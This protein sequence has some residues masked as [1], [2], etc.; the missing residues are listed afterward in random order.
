MSQLSDLVEDYLADCRAR[1]LSRKTVVRIYGGV[2]S[3]DFLPWCAKASLE[4]I[5]QVDQR[6]LNRWSATLSDRNLTPATISSYTRALN[7]FLRWAREEGG[8]GVTAHLPKQP[9]KIVETLTEEEIDQLAAAAK[10]KRDELIVRTLAGTG[11]RAAELLGMTLDDLRDEGGRYFIRVRMGKGGKSRDVPI[12]PLLFRDLRRYARGT[13]TEG[14]IWLGSN[15][16]R[17]TG[18]YEPLTYDGLHQVIQALTDRAGIRR[19][20]Y[21]HIFRHT[22]I[23]NQLRA[24]MDSELLRRIVGHSNTALISSTYGHVVSGDLYDAIVRADQ[25]R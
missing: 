13:K 4:E 19:R 3:K 2:L 9:K 22:Y 16:S 5:G 24:G 25:P 21:P 1:G 23:T 10:T 11:L 12:L 6:V 14:R 8:T 20:V 18:L 17:K 15:R 7:S